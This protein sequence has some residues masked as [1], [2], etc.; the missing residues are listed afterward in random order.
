MPTVDDALNFAK[1]HIDQSLDRLFALLRI[2]SVS[3]DPAYHQ[4]CVNAA[5]WLVAEL[6]ELGFK[7]SRRETDGKPMVLAHGGPEPGNGAGPHILFYGHYDVQPPDPLDLWNTPPFEPTIVDTP[8]GKQ[9]V[10]RGACDDKG[11]LLTFVEA[12]RAYVG[13]TGALPLPM[14]I[15]FEGEEE[16]GSPSLGPFLEGHKD[17]LKA[18]VALVCDTGMWNRE[19]PA[20]TTRLR[21]LVADEIVIEAADR[22]LHSGMYGSAARNPIRLL[23]R[24]LAAIHD[25]TNKVMIPGFYEGVDE[26]TPE[27]KAQWDGL[28]FDADG[29]LGEI[30]LSVPAGETDRSVLEQVWARP[31]AE[32]NGIIGG[33]T[34]AGTKT[35]IPAKASAKITFRLVGNQDPDKIRENFQRF[36]RARVPADCTVTFLNDKSA[37]PALELPLDSPYLANAREA[38]AE[39]WGK[40]AALIGSGGSI[41][42]VGDFKRELGMDSLLVGF[43]LDD[44]R[45]HSPNEKYDLR[46]FE[47]G[48]R[49]WI[50]ILDRLAA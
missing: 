50:R 25:D 34:G 3:T 41:P 4:D 40:E 14:T 5:D 38:L 46:S 6:S 7:A 19:T 33:Y 29:F 16:S 1:S 27:I 44:D 37:S 31:T 48:I 12:C 15:L 20:I 30:G 45:L 26:L 8:T 42:I 32:I 18:D 49:S 17:E 39:E 9:I 21:G 11:Q 28:G 22:D 2:P 35:V 47:G 23:A 13:T 43:G 36:V 10:A 24:I